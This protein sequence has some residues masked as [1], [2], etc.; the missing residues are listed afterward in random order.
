M[1]AAKWASAHVKP[2]K[3]VSEGVR[4]R[5]TFR[6]YSTLLRDSKF[7]DT[8]R[9]LPSAELSTSADSILTALA[10]LGACHTGTDRAF[11]SLF[12][13]DH[14]YIIAEATPSIALCPSLPSGEC[15]D[16]LWSCG[17][18]IPRGHGTCELPLLSNHPAA[19]AAESESNH[20]P[21]TLSQDLTTDARFS[22]KHNCQPGSG[23]RFYA[24]V[25]IRTQR[26][27]NIGVYCVMNT[28]PGKAWTIEYTSRL[29]EISHAIMNRL[30]SQ[31][32][33]DLRWRNERMIKSFGCFIEGKST[34]SEWP[35]GL[36]DHWD[37][38]RIFH[39]TQ[40]F[41]QDMQ[42]KSPADES[43]TEF[44][45]SPFSPIEIPPR[46]PLLRQSSNPLPISP[47]WVDM[48]PDLG[49][50]GNPTVIFSKAA[51]IIRESI[52]VE[53]CLFFDA[54]MAAYRA[55]STNHETPD[56]FDQSSSASSHDENQSAEYGE[57]LSPRCQLLGSSAPDASTITRGIRPH[58][59]AIVMEKFLAKLLRRY[60]KGKIFNF[61]ADGELQSSDYSEDDGHLSQSSSIGQQSP[62]PSQKTLGESISF[63]SRPRRH[64]KTRTRQREGNIILEAFPGARSVA[65]VPIW[66]PRKERWYAGG[67]IYTNTPSRVFSLEVELNYLRVFGMLSIS[68]ILRFTTLLDNK[69]KSDA[70]G[71]LSHELRSP[72]HGVL[73]SAE[74]LMDTDLNV[75]QDNATHTIE[76][77]SR[78]LLDT[79][80][81]LLDYSKINS[82]GKGRSV[83][84]Q[85]GIS[86]VAGA[87]T[88]WKHFGRKSLGLNARLDRL[89]EEVIESVFAGF[90][91]Q[92]LSIKKPSHE[93]SR[94]RSSDINTNQLVDPQQA[95][96]QPD[97]DLTNNE[98]LQFNF[99]NVFISISINSRHNWMYFVQVGAF[100]RILMNIFGNALKY[101]QNGTIK[102]SLTQETLSIKRRKKERIVK[103]TV[104]DTG[105]GI[106]A[107]YLKQ[108]LF[109]PFSQ[110]DSLAPGT[111][112][113]LSLVKQITSQLGGQITVGSKVGIGTT[114]TVVLPLERVPHSHAGALP[115]S[116][117]DKEFDV[118]VQDLKG[119]RVRM[120]YPSSDH[121][122]GTESHRQKLEEICTEWLQMEVISDAQSAV[123]APDLILWSQDTLPTIVEEI[124]TL[125]KTPNIAICSNA[126]EAY[127]Q[128]QVF[129]S[130]GHAGIFE[131]LSQPYNRSS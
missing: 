110:E 39:S 16:R 19:N 2:L 20:L 88:D 93:R 104:Q 47:A 14:Q 48:E 96:E 5:E 100:R 60:P 87:Q 24:A 49:D 56:N 90:N 29:Q 7:N 98:E 13:T 119:L 123:L 101:T 50:D 33:M 15:S 79:I 130:V 40:P 84:K 103:L 46:P 65:F 68:E 127:R 118:R 72:L 41:P 4:E 55:P 108:G 91:F 115:L 89:V 34:I 32:A 82:F 54:T 18:A 99:A 27:I 102:V 70:L 35:F 52:D 9:P 61:G 25:P 121:G 71:S 31:A 3:Q 22:S 38:D 74:L 83:M 109:E 105:R 94:S 86:T 64:T 62:L 42:A 107:E 66:D 78:T 51:T 122:A 126:I 120:M 6:Y 114:V 73:L 57:T 80:D 63:A 53:G 1:T 124:D 97:S 81:H 75:F 67:F 106:S 95:K 116:D 23:A 30:E 11:I 128:S 112:L 58:Q 77:C 21:L 17:T 76:T 28:T 36:A 129:E 44:P 113:G 117:D 10:Q 125:A 92:H 12:D 45:T 8:G 111:G 37:Q 69:A 85:T 43:P 26:G 59:D 131:F